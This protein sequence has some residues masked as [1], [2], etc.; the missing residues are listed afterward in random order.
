[1]RN[2]IAL[3]AALSIGATSAVAAPKTKQLDDAVVI[4]RIVMSMSMA[5]QVCQ[6]FMTVDVE[7]AKDVMTL[8]VY[9]GVMLKG[10][11]RFNKL[12]TAEFAGFNKSIN[13]A[14]VHQ[15]CLGLKVMMHANGITNIMP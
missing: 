13:K 1:M 14:N 5:T 10:A 7:K 8:G 3:I 12:V 11:D 4:A 6:Q 2:I 9:N 15:W